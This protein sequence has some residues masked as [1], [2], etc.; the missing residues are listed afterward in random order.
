[1][2]KNW[3]AGVIATGAAGAAMTGI[4]LGS[5][6]TGTEHFSFISTSTTNEAKYSAIA[7]G[8]ITAGGTAELIG[9]KGKIVFPT[10]TIKVTNKLTGNPTQTGSKQN[11]IA[12]YSEKGTYTVTGGTGAYTGITGSGQFSL[13]TTGVGMLKNGKCDTASSSKPV[14][15]QSTITASGPITDAG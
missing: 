9:E 7:T 4:A 12:I 1:M 2:S 6:A 8:P 15:S 5:G 3:I 14:A 10:G 11:C 13:K